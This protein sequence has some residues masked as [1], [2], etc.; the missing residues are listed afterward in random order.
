MRMVLS[1]AASLALASPVRAAAGSTNLGNAKIGTA[2]GA[3][4]VGASTLSTPVTL[5]YSATTKGFSV[6][7]PPGGT[8]A[9]DPTTASGSSLKLSVSG[10]GDLTFS[11]TGTPTTGDTFS[12]ASN[13]GGTG[14]NTNALALAGLQDTQTLRGGLSLAQ[15]Y[16]RAVSSI[17]SRTNALELSATAQEALLQQTQDSRQSESGVNLDEEAAA[18]LQYQNSYN[19]A[20][21]VIT[22]ANELFQTLLDAMRG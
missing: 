4:L 13:V 5:T 7:T 10:F 21:K 9:Y 16:E 11:I 22:V 18:L 15:G 20:A 8:L 3:N 14:D 12:V 2:A 6:S 17:G 19:A 1:N